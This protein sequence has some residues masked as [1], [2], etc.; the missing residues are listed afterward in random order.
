MKWVLLPQV[1]VV[2]P[3]QGHPHEVAVHEVSRLTAVTVEE[4]GGEKGQE[5]SHRPICHA[6]LQSPH[7][8]HQ[9]APVHIIERHKQPHVHADFSARVPAAR[10]HQHQICRVTSSS[11]EDRPDE[12]VSGSMRSPET[13]HAYQPILPV[14]S[15]FQQI[16]FDETK[17]VGNQAGQNY[18][19]KLV[20]ANAAAGKTGATHFA[21]EKIIRKKK[22]KKD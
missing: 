12:S 1:V 3:G 18:V 8:E 13:L 17:K 10:R 5:Q 6:Q 19:S 22:L 20:G 21:H 15:L 7:L 9:M 14:R 11:V 2:S 16:V 4:P